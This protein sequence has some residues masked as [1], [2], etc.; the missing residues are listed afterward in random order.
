MV[1]EGSFDGKEPAFV[2]EAPYRYKFLMVWLRATQFMGP[3][4][5]GTPSLQHQSQMLTRVACVL[6]LSTRSVLSLSMLLTAI[7]AQDGPWK[8]KDKP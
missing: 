8:M 1:T 6:S 5:N 3:E 2:V 4:A 7:V